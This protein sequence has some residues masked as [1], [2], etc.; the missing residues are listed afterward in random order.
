MHWSFYCFSGLYFLYF[1]SDSIIFFLLLT[2]RLIY[3]LSSYWICKFWDIYNFLMYLFIV[4]NFPIRTAFV[5]FHYI[6]YIVFSSSFISQYIF[7]SHLIPSL[8]PWFRN[9]LLSFYVFVDLLIFL[10]LISS[11]VPLKL[12][13]FVISDFLNFLR[14]ILWPIIWLMLENFPCALENNVHHLLLDWIFCT[15]L[16]SPFVLRCGSIPT[17]PWW[18]SV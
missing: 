7:V 18:L 9:M 3:S 8:T 12:E 4:I 11:F 5:A 17:F 13:K 15:H 1:F 6:W 2:L 14:F 10:L 16:L